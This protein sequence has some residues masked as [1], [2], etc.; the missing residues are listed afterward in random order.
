MK[1]HATDPRKGFPTKSILKAGG[2]R[3]YDDSVRVK[4]I[5]HEKILFFFAVKKKIS[6]FLV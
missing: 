3:K 5:P 6:H 1:N 4:P 2:S